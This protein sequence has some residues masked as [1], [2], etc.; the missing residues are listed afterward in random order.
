MQPAALNAFFRSLGIPYRG[1]E[2]ADPGAIVAA[3]DAIGRLENKP[4]TY[5]E[6]VPRV[7]YESLCYGSAAACLLIVL[8]ARLAERDF[9][10]KDAQA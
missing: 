10:G 3:T 7:G 4:V 6:T 2:A 1:F 8:L 9:A 5:H